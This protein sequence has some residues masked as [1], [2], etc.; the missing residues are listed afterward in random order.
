MNCRSCL[1]IFFCLLCGL[2]FSLVFLD[3]APGQLRLPLIDPVML[4]P[5]GRLDFAPIRES[6]GLV[7]SRVW[8][9]VF[10]TLNDSG[11]PPK[12]FPVRRDGGIIRPAY[13]KRS[14]RKYDGTTVRGATNRDWEDIAADDKGNLIVADIGD[15]ARS[16]RDLVL[17][18][19]REPNPYKS[20]V[21]T[22]R[23]KIS[24]QYP[25][26]EGRGPGRVNF[27]AEAIFWAC[28]HLYLLTKHWGDTITRLYRFD[29]LHPA[30]TNTPTLL[31]TFDIHGMVTAADATA[32][33]RKL[34]VLTYNAVWL[35]EVG[36]GSDDYFNGVIRWL[37]ISAGQCEAITF[38]GDNL[39]ITNEA[40]DVFELPISSLRLIRKEP[41]RS[42]ILNAPSRRTE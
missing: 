39:L 29:T 42:S 14:P 1:T 37:P 12:I 10:W 11:N 16:R 21:A 2:V 8:P 6:S 41:P 34:A 5:T 4:S 33:G 25:R 9:D 36:E 17:Y 13:A 22:V 26:E 32:D 20:G 40:R 31:G 23:S 18:I 7:K 28:G 27:D 35:F 15:N 30:S 19:V 3:R 24:F 38:H